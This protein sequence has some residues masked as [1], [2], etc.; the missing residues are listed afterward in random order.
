LGHREYALVARRANSVALIVG[1]SPRRKANRCN[2]AFIVDQLRDACVGAIRVCHA[3][4][5]FQH[6]P[7]MQQ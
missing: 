3:T 1:A 6:V 7:E 4:H 5:G 2:D